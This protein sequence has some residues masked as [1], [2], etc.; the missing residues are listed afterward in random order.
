MNFRSRSVHPYARDGLASVEIA[1]VPRRS[2]RDLRDPAR[3]RRMHGIDPATT[4]RQAETRVS[5]T[6]RTLQR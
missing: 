1:A 2:A 4:T 5:A 6:F 3:T